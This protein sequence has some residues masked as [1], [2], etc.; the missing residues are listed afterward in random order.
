MRLLCV[1]THG[2][3]CVLQRGQTATVDTSDPYTVLIRVPGQYLH[4]QYNL[5]VFITVKPI[6][7]VNNGADL[8]W[9]YI[10]AKSLE[11]G[12]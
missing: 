5:L 3:C 6:M 8:G 10:S 12:F 9:S 7:N 4:E 11:I 1:V 2:L